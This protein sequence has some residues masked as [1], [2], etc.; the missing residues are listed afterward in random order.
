[1][2]FR[3]FHMVESAMRDRRCTRSEVALHKACL[4][5]KPV[6]FAFLN[7]IDLWLCYIGPTGNDLS[8]DLRVCRLTSKPVQQQFSAEEVSATSLRGSLRLPT[9]HTESSGIHHPRT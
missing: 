9:A 8:S 1:M 2:T 3:L 7:V 6:F 5:L 4:D